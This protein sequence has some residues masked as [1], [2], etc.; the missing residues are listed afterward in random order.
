MREEEQE[1]IVTVANDATRFSEIFTN[2]HLQPAG[3][4]FEDGSTYNAFHKFTE[5]IT[6]TRLIRVQKI[7]NNNSSCCFFVVVDFCV[8]RRHPQ[9]STTRNIS[10]AK[11]CEA[12]FSAA[13]KASK[14]AASAVA[15]PRKVLVK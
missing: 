15:S 14:V 12:D 2:G 5:V 13:Q 1:S 9:R 10:T 11:T 8:K 3:I 6:T 4:K 7:Q